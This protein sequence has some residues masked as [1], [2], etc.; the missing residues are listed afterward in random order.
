MLNLD[1]DVLADIRD[2]LLSDMKRGSYGKDDVSY[3]SG[4]VNGVLDFFNEL[5]HK[6]ENGER[7]FE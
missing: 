4:Y 7:L 6:S 2:K 3:R 1:Q 5:K